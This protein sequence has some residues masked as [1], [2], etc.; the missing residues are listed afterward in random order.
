MIAT[1]KVEERSRGRG[2]RSL[3]V[4]KE[5]GPISMRLQL[6]PTGLMEACGLPLIYPQ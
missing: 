4:Q 6:F 3:A 1:F 2:I 5:R